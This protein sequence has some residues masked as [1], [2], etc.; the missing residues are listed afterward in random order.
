MIPPISR[1]LPALALIALLVIPATAQESAVKGS[2]WSDPSLRLTPI[3]TH[4]GGDPEEV[5]AGL[6]FL[7]R[8]G[9]GRSLGVAAADSDELL[10]HLRGQLRSRLDAL[11]DQG[12]FGTAELKK[13]EW[14]GE[15]DIARWTR[16]ARLVDQRLRRMAPEQPGAFVHRELAS[17]TTACRGG[18]FDAPSLFARVL[19]RLTASTRP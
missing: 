3:V 15:L 17:L 14:A 9:D 13:L 6:L 2:V 18:L 1:A 11:R 12:V 5:P 7:L 16:H 10:R 19:E 8:D 4:G